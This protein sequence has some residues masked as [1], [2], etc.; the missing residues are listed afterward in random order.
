MINMRAIKS[1]LE[2]F[3]LSSVLETVGAD[4]IR[5]PT[6]A[7]I[8]KFTPISFV[9]VNAMSIKAKL[10]SIKPISHKLRTL[11]NGDTSITGIRSKVINILP[12]STQTIPKIEEYINTEGTNA[13]LAIE[14]IAEFAPEIRNIAN[15]IG[16]MLK[17]DF[18]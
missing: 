18:W 15:S 10:T 7:S 13:S 14:C 17:I 9:V 11:L 6:I 2:K 16:N 3:E 1:N 8:Q 5:K 4:V 12:N